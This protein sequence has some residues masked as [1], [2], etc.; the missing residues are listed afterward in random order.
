MSDTAD[1]QAPASGNDAASSNGAASGTDAASGND[2]ISGTD[3]ASGTGAI[4][5]TDA[6]SG[7]EAPSGNGAACGN[8][9]PASG[10]L[11]HFG[12]L[13]F[14][15]PDALGFLQGQVSN[16]T[17]SLGNG[18]PMLAAYSTP[19]GRVVAVLHLLPHSSGVIAL[20]PR[21]I[22]LPTLERLRK[23][24]LRAKVK[25]EDLSE[26][27]AV[28]G[29]Y[30]ST[31]AAFGELPVP[32]AAQGYAERNGIGVARVGSDPNRYWII[33]PAQDL[34]S[35]GTEDEPKATQP[36]GHDWRL[37]D[38]RSGLP[39]VYAATREMFVAQMLNLDLID[40]IS[41]T[42]GCFTGQE[43]IARTQHLGRIKRRL[44]RLRLPAGTW[45][46][47]QAVHLAD[48]RNGRLTELAQTG[49][50]FEALA[51]LSIDTKAVGRDA[52]DPES[53]TSTL[54]DA[55]ELPLPYAVG[56]T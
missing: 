19:Q 31:A 50:G 24:V 9:A 49:A 26:E 27:F 56:S 44:F 8:E 33:G 53:T 51:V 32:D 17:R 39:Q 54:I 14:A 43:I 48:G 29:R 42:K 13:R 25:I 30:R 12:L 6:A 28:V 10:R 20:L 35:H 5:G 22:V 40:G 52:A 2:A 36:A 38:I 1:K 3:A 15:G 55:A 45:A 37:A 4:S 21:E 41:F 46:I 16:D 11:P 34:M 18:M 7:N 23:Y 47:G